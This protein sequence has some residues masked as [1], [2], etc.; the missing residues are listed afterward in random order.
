MSIVPRKTTRILATASNSPLQTFN[1]TCIVR[2]V[3][4][5]YG[6]SKEVQSWQQKQF[7][8]DTIP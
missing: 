8:M 6:L 2:G 7:P 3:F 1:A 4:Q 5:R